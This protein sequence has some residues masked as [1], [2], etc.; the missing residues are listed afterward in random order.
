MAFLTQRIQQAELIDDPSV[1]FV[2]FQQTLS[3]IEAINRRLGSYRPT[4]KAIA[5]LIQSRDSKQPLRILDIG[6]G[7]G[8]FLRRI[9]QWAS[10]QN[11]EVSLHGVDLNPWAAKAA[12]LITPTAMNIQYHTSN[13]FDFKAEAPFDIIINSF[14]THHLSNSA[15]VQVMRWMTANARLGWIINDL[16]RHWLPYYFI[17]YYVRLLGYNHLV[18]NDAPLSVARSFKRA[19][20]E[21]SVKVSGLN[22]NHIE[23]AWLWPF[24]YRVTYAA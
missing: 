24:R 7:N 21:Q 2:D 4:L 19:D 12:G 11:I 5:Q 23:I 6:F 10:D 17:T 14:F 18:R 13:I 20:W 15:I 9:H 16:H 8:D 3:Q 1:S 22:P